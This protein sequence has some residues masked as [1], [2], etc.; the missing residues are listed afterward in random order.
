MVGERRRNLEGRID[1]P[2][3]PGGPWARHRLLP[4]GHLYSECFKATETATEAGGCQLPP[5][6]SC[7]H[8]LLLCQRQGSSGQP[9]GKLKFQPLQL[10][11]GPDEVSLCLKAEEGHPRPSSCLVPYRWDLE[12]KSPLPLWTKS[13]E[14][15]LGCTLLQI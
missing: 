1:R 3:S 14:G 11:H 5:Y 7:K 10:E 9:W 8:V 12:K 15:R 2:S 6:L 13:T 4:L